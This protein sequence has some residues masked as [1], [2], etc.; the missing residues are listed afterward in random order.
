MMDQVD[1]E[2]VDYVETEILPKYAE[3]GVVRGAINGK[4]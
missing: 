3:F 1:K 2:I 4:H